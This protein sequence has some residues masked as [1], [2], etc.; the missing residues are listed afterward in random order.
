VNVS[1]PFIRRPVG[2]SLLAAGLFLAGIVAYQ[3]LPVAPIPRVDFPMITVQATLPGAD[4][5]TVA[6]TV[7]APLERR[8]GQ[9]S[10]VSEI[11]SV[12]TL[13]GT[14]I[15]IQFSLD[16]SVDRAARDVQAAINASAGDLPI[17]LPA[18][19][20]YRK[21]NPADAPIM[22]LAMTSDTL[23]ATQIY[24][25]GDTIIAQRLSQ[26]EGVSQVF[27]SGAAKDAIRIQVNPAT[28][29]SAGLSLEDVRSVLGQVNVDEPKG[30]LEGNGASYTINSND[31]LLRAQ[32]YQTLVL[33]EK[34]KGP[35]R[36]RA[37]GRAIDSVENTRQ[38]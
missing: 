3:F 36:L 15:S 13:G 9:I 38:A 8:L 37:M 11:T 20:T 6:S 30:S 10:G 31:Q 21:T 25:Y 4:P 28:L 29:A 1:E 2:T 16:R 18:P 23:P 19:P 35:V 5:T 34:P 32:D 33:A 22:I 26:I 14:A 17:N 24:D 27:I 12:S 7:A